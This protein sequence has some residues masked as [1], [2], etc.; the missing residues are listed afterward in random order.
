MR[1]VPFGAIGVAFLMA[2]PSSMAALISFDDATPFNFG[3]S[4]FFLHSDP[5]SGSGQKL[6]RLDDT[7]PSIDPFDMIWNDANNDGRF[8]DTETI[9]SVSGDSMIVPLL[10][11][12]AKSDFTATLT[13][14]D[15]TAEFGGDDHGGGLMGFDQKKDIVSAS[16][17]FELEEFDTVNNITTMVSGI[18]TYG[19]V[20]SG[21]FNHGFLED[22]GG[23][24]Y[25]TQVFLWG[26]LGGIYGN[27]FSAE[28]TAVPEPSTLALL[29]I[30]CAAIGLA[31]RRKSVAQTRR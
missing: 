10:G 5:T 9:S 7:S 13:I 14:T 17:Q 18:A 1:V 15:W 3:G 23:G 19:P 16:Y 29:G 26:N 8:S 31:R 2:S 25:F 4:T 30:G 28:A 20:S 24:Q 11:M 27:D 12:N 6:Y 21:V 22:L